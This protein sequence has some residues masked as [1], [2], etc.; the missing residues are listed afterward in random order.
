MNLRTSL[1]LL[2]FV[3]FCFQLNAQ[4]TPQD[5][6]E[7]A[8]PKKQ[9][10]W[11]T[12][13][14]IGLDFAQ[15][16]QVNPRQGAGQNRIGLGSATNIFARYKKNR[17]AW[18][19]AANWQ[20]GVQRLGAGV[21]A[22]ALGDKNIPF[23]K[24]IDEF[25]INSKFGYRTSKQSKFFYAAN[26]S[27][28][29]QITNTYQGNDAFPGNFLTDITGEGRLLSKFFSPATITISVGMDLKPTDQLS[30][31]YSPVGGKFIIVRDNQIAR[32]GVHGNP[33]EGEKNEQ[34]V[35]PEFRNTFTALGSLLRMNY[36][37]AFF[38]EKLILNSSL[39][40]FSNYIENPQNI[41]V[42][43]TNE[44]ALK[45]SKGFQAALTVNVFYDDDV[46]VQITD[47][48][49][50]NGVSG[51]GKR[52]SLTQQFLLKYNLAF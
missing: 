36:D 25:R 1:S 42:D 43:W 46:M 31:Y 27:F 32:L 14:G 12:G 37:S 3:I 17:I 47:Y 28:L 50:P 13:A 34:G 38:D 16:L 4:N 19:N 20:F 7:A 15:L 18:D 49:E 10:V 8:A 33:V 21:I 29:S 6:T 11:K 44:L 9:E 48:D 23:Q 51:L 40:L 30:F 26:V 41:D 22:Q 2:T 24:S 52:V 35:Y 39:T 45:I 5:T